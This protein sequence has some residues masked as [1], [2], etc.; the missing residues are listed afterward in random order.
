MA[1]LRILRAEASPTVT[2]LVEGTLDAASA[3]L[4]SE[5][6]ATLT[7]QEVVVD[8]S[9]VRHFQDAAVAVLSPA[10][11]GRAHRLLGLSPHHSHVCRCFGLSAGV[12]SGAPETSTRSTQE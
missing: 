1:T 5:S 6:L 12:G 8:F 4:V 7:A 3:A 10:L 11:A 2:L 9:R